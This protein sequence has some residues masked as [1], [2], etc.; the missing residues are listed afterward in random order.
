MATLDLDST[1]SRS[2]SL[3]AALV[4]MGSIDAA[5]FRLYAGLVRS[6][7]SLDLF[8]LTHGKQRGCLHVHFVDAPPGASDWGELHSHRRVRAVIGL[9]HCPSEADLRASYAAFIATQVALFPYTSQL[10]CLAFEAPATGIP[11]DELPKGGEK[12]LMVVPPKRNTN[13]LQMYALRLMEDLASDLLN[14][15]RAEKAVQPSSLLTP[16]DSTTPTASSASRLASAVVKAA[17]S[18]AGK[19]GGREQKRLADLH[20]IGGE[21]AEARALYDKAVEQ[22]AR[23]TVAADSVWHAAALEGSVAATL[24][25]QAATRRH[26]HLPEDEARVDMLHG[27]ITKMEEVVSI[28]AR[29]GGR[30][31][32]L[33]VEAGFRLAR[34]V[35]AL[36]QG[37]RRR[38]EKELKAMTQFDPEEGKAPPCAWR[39]HLVE[40]QHKLIRHAYEPALRNEKPLGLQLQLRVVLAAAALSVE[41]GHKRK[42]AFFLLEAA[43]RYADNM[44]WHAAHEVLLAASLHGQ[45]GIMP[46]RALLTAVQQR[47]TPP[48]PLGMLRTCTTGWLQL[49]RWLLEQLLEAAAG[50]DTAGALEA[51]CLYTLYMLRALHP[52]LSEER[53]SQLV[54]QLLHIAPRLPP[55]LVMPAVGLPWLLSLQPIVLPTELLPHLREEVKT[56]AASIFT[57]SPF[58]ATRRR[59][60]TA[61]LALRVLWVCGEI[62]RVTV[63]ISNPLA[64]PLQLQSLSLVASV[65]EAPPPSPSPLDSAAT[66]ATP[67]LFTPFPRALSLGPHQRVELALSG[68]I[69]GASPSLGWRLRLRGVRARA[70]GVECVHPVDEAAA[71]VHL[72]PVRPT[73]R[74]DAL[75]AALPPPLAVP[76]APS[77]PLLTVTPHASLVVFPGE[78]ASLALHLLNS[79]ACAVRHVVARLEPNGA[80]R[81][82]HLS[83]F[84]W[85]EMQPALLFDEAEATQ[86]AAR[87]HFQIDDDA[88]TR[89]LPLEVGRRLALPLEVLALTPKCSCT[90]MLEYGVADPN[91]QGSWYRKLSVP[92]ALG[93][94]AGLSVSNAVVL[95]DPTLSSAC[96]LLLEVANEHERLSFQ[97]SAHCS[98]HRE[99]GTWI[100]PPRAARRL[101]LRL[102]RFPRDGAHPFPHSQAMLER[103]LREHQPA[104]TPPQLRRLRLAHLAK[105][106]LLAALRLEWRQVGGEARGEL[107]LSSLSLSPAH[108]HAL[109]LPALRIAAAAAPVAAPPH[110]A[111]M[112]LRRLSVSLTNASAAPL[113]AGGVLRL[114]CAAAAP[115]PPP[116]PPPPAPPPPPPPPP[117]PVD[118]M[119]TPS[120]AD[121]SAASPPAEFL[122]PAEIALVGS[123][124]E[125]T[126]PPSGDLPSASPATPATQ[127]LTSASPHSCSTPSEWLSVPVVPVGRPSSLSCNTS[128]GP[129][130]DTRPS[131]SSGNVSG[132][133]ELEASRGEELL[134]TAS[135]DEVAVRDHEEREIA[136]STPS[137]ERKRVS[138]GKWEAW[139]ECD[140]PDEGDDRVV[141]LGAIDAVVPALQPEQSHEHELIVGL[142][143]PGAYT[144]TMKYS[145]PGEDVDEDSIAEAELCIHIDNESSPEW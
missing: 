33:Q 105:A 58:E 66:A 70:C 102:P 100:L 34:L 78:R 36:A 37:E 53:Q 115:P 106:R 9:C 132:G 125:A 17:K 88:L 19:L 94:A 1:L 111:A 95:P 16:L 76:L 31:T 54:N 27:A 103:Y 139:D 47:D 74:I 131:V 133:S 46:L 23:S 77:L 13:D 134:E 123:S 10:R 61:R 120:P 65:E 90:L 42:A 119:R 48:A 8:E 28:Y 24:L 98:S 75:A 113:A 72:P 5:T 110:F 130:T 99:E 86:L 38:G 2:F 83:K 67:P 82:T 85:Y 135:H 41:W 32:E 108:A 40:A 92:V 7:P 50:C 126:P 145:A 129:E 107:R 118:A 73:D 79:G 4:P 81:L 93:V 39:K 116:P 55:G 11:E 57:F 127:V 141:W 144:F 21:V 6:L 137:L 26:N 84:T 30:A 29:R 104:L 114:R 60:E 64:V 71:P 3:R 22:L 15:L 117:P 49:G 142:L 20:M 124:A 68:R 143:Q 35:G 51:T 63:A 138:V 101:L 140:L 89:Q 87:D 59:Q 62:V 128:G 121:K 122:G 136:P 43:R 14:D 80:P 109:L 12:H 44:Q 96:V 56:Q 45:F 69:G 25:L 18:S 52:F 112:W 91:T 97:V